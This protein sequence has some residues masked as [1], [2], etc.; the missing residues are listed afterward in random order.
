MVADVDGLSCAVRAVQSFAAITI[1]VVVLDIVVHQRC[2]VKCFNGHRDARDGIGTSGVSSPV[3]SGV[4][5][6]AAYQAARVIKGRKRFPP[7]AASHTKSIRKR[8]GT[9]APDCIPSSNSWQEA[10]EVL[11]EHPSRCS[12]QR[13]I[14]RRGLLRQ[15]FILIQHVPDPG[16]V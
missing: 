6:E 3:K 1:G 4:R 9:V 11:L 8:D 2:F 5:P 16:F 12:H 15:W 14:T 7:L 13:H 10:I